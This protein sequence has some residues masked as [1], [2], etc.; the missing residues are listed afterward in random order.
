MLLF[1]KPTS[2]LSFCWGSS[3]LLQKNWLAKPGKKS[4]PPLDR[5]LPLPV[6][7]F[8]FCGM[9]THS[10]LWLHHYQLEFLVIRVVECASRCRL[11]R[12]VPGKPNE[13]IWQIYHGTWEMV[14]GRW[15][16][17]GDAS[18]RTLAARLKLKPPPQFCSEGGGTTRATRADKI[19][20]SEQ[21]FNH[22]H[23]DVPNFLVIWAGE[24][25]SP[26]S[27]RAL[28]KC[29]SRQS[30]GPGKRRSGPAVKVVK[31]CQT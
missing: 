4:F 24:T 8:I 22:V 3:V 16:R 20:V 25:A 9:P 17:G 2:P 21:N 19:A 5:P 27:W 26:A 7:E 12:K 31:T 23:L 30:G 10:Q 15:P 11:T 13:A 6:E 1:T 29:W 14:A 28:P 18:P